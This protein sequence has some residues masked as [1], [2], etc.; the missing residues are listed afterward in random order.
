VTM[1]RKNGKRIANQ[2]HSGL[3]GWES[4]GRNWRGDTQGKT[5]NGQ[6]NGTH[7]QDF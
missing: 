1:A 4:R 3:K 5:T 7:S 6:E 2:A